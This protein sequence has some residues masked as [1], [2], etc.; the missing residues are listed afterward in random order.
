MMN[1]LFWHNR[2]DCCFS[3]SSIFISS[4][5]LSDQ[6]WW[7]YIKCSEFQ[8]N[9]HYNGFQ[10]SANFLWAQSENGVCTS[11]SH[12]PC[13]PDFP[14]VITAGSMLAIS[15][16]VPPRVFDISECH[17]VG[18]FI[19]WTWKGWQPVSS[20]ELIIKLYIHTYMLQPSIKCFHVSHGYIQ[21]IISYI[22]NL[23]LY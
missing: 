10:R 6:C 16:W 3:L 2:Q 18:G 1:Y 12:I 14:V 19:F 5:L 20:Y 15:S 23:C 8:W 21:Y 17:P 9:C 22:N 13:S 7:R 11:L 4:S